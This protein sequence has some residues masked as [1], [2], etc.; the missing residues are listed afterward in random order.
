MNILRP[1]QDGYAE[2]VAGFQTS[3]ASEPAVVVAAEN[4]DDVVAAV[5]YAAEHDLP[6]AVQ[7]TGHG[8]TAGADGLLISTRRMTD[9]EI[10]AETQ[11][12]RVGA[13]VHWGAVIDAA[14]KHGLAPLSG[15]S[16]DVGVV[17]Y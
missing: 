9:V 12:A 13:G 3:V 17:G 2:E 5:K 7:A 11:T 14:A 8:L 4:A 16:P 6:V 10:G 15:S 1:G